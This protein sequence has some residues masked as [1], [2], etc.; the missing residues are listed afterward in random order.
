MADRGVTGSGV[1]SP[2]RRHEPLEA[3]VATVGILGH[4]SI[5]R[6]ADDLGNRDAA[7]T[8]LGTKAT[9]LLHGQRNLCPDHAAMISLILT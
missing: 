7:S 9:H 1:K 6:V 8:G 5:Y 3:H 4:D 2:A